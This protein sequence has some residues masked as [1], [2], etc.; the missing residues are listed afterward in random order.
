MLAAERPVFYTGGGVINSGVEASEALRELVRATGFPITSTLMGLGAYPA[1]DAQWLGMLGM[2]GTY[3]ANKTMHAADLI[4][5]VGA[6]FDDRVTGTVK[7]FA[8]HAKKIHI[9]VDPSSIN[10]IVRVDLGIAADCQQAL[11]SM[12]VAWHK[13]AANPSAALQPWWD[14]IKA[15]RAVDSLNYKRS[16]TVIKPQ[17]VIQTLAALTTGKD[18][19]F[20]TDVGQHQMWAAQHLKLEKPNHLMTSGGLGTM[21]YGL[22]AAIGVQMA[23][24]ES[25]VVCISG[26]G[27]IQMNIQEMAT[28]TQEGLAIKVIVINNKQL[29]MVRQWQ[30]L[31]HGNR[32]SQSEFECQPDFVLLAKAYGWTGAHCTKPQELEP[33]LRAMIDTPGPYIL[34]CRVSATENCYPM[35]PP[36]RAHNEMVL[37]ADAA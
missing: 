22:P 8:P 34:D 9:D 16:E 32:H 24:P 12:S 36:G 26:D 20:A 5:A 2:H 7:D 30:D 3:E 27:S 28:A 25:L 6:R 11:Q 17:A 29:G 4:I 14:Q 10:K 15:W 23:H 33:A 35:I 31:C 19:Y 21:G 18:A 1:S 13:I 37:G